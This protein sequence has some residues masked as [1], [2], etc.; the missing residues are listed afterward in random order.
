MNSKLTEFL[1]QELDKIE[2]N[3]TYEE[4]N[5][6][7]SYLL[8]NMPQ[9]N[10]VGK[11]R[12]S[13]VNEFLR[14]LKKTQF[15]K[16]QKKRLIKLILDLEIDKLAV[17][18]KL[19]GIFNYPFPYSNLHLSD[20]YDEALRLF[21]DESLYNEPLEDTY[22][23]LPHLD[24]E[25][26]SNHEKYKICFIRFVEYYI[27]KERN[28]FSRYDSFISKL[29][30]KLYFDDDSENDEYLFEENEYAD[31]LLDLYD[32]YVD[33]LPKSTDKRIEFNQFK[34]VVLLG[35]LEK[36][37]SK[38]D[39]EKNYFRQI[40]MKS[41]ESYVVQVLIDQVN[42]DNIYSYNF[43][44]TFYNGIFLSCAKDELHELFVNY[45]T[46]VLISLQELIEGFDELDNLT[47]DDL[48]TIVTSFKNTID[49]YAT[50]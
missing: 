23:Q 45:F 33:A 48:R 21:I 1:N 39:K 6:L 19:Y 38:Q 34:Y 8:S 22:E 4:A 42:Y 9:L 46:E 16:P 2:D 17:I 47:E 26:Q 11:K 32:H 36:I 37:F 5:D 18:N 12:Q 35:I 31:E 15:V 10:S 30:M 44:N 13:I 43:L 29:F 14:E 25:P 49:K 28:N 7:L 40:I 20:I 3:N 41:T 27:K 50:K 24:G